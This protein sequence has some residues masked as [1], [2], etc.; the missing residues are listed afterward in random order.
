MEDKGYV[1]SIV[2]FAK[3]EEDRRLLTA[4]SAESMEASIENERIAAKY[5]R[6]NRYKTRQRR[7]PICDQVKPRP[8]KYLRDPIN[9]MLYFVNIARHKHGLQP[10]RLDPELIRTAQARADDMHDKKYF[11]HQDLD[12]N[13]PVYA[14]NLHK[15]FRFESCHTSFRSWS[16]STGHHDN[17]MNP[18]HTRMGVGHRIFTYILSGKDKSGHSLWVQHF[19]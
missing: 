5:K 19:A 7:C 17:M 11:D 12:G 16:A 8:K 2:H 3:S 18:E 10:V 1:E 4:F 6:V 13:W 15:G 14:E 9:G